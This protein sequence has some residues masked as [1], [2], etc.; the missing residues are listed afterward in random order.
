MTD[1]FSNYPKSLSELKS[2]KTALAADNTPRDLLIKVLRDI[3]AGNINP[4]DLVIAFSD[5]DADGA[6][7]FAWL[8]AGPDLAVHLGMLALTINR[9]IEGTMAAR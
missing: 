6:R 2:D 7:E 9:M 4:S 1:D 5:L 3:D 8:A